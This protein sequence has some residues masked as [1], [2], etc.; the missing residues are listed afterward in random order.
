MTLA[1]NAA[2]RGEPTYPALEDF[3]EIVRHSIALFER[4]AASDPSIP[5]PQR[6]VESLRHLFGWIVADLYDWP[7]SS[8]QHRKSCH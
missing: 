3:V 7:D 1:Q 5:E 8:M 2:C 4:T 6:Q